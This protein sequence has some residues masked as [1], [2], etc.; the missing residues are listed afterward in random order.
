MVVIKCRS[1]PKYDKLLSYTL[2]LFISKSLVGKRLGVRDLSLYHLFIEVDVN[3]RISLKLIYLKPL[4]KIMNKKICY[5]R[6]HCN[7]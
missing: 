7:G 2:L 6:H 4:Y 3:I 5:N 1:T